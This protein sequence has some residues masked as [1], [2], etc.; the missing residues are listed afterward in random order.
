M[1]EFERF[2]KNINLAHLAYVNGAD[3]MYLRIIK[4]LII[5]Y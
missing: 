3:E 2:E 1:I 5:I 4:N